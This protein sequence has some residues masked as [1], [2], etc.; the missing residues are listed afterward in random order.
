[1]TEWVPEGQT[2]NQTS[3]WKVLVTLQKRVHKKQPELWKNK[4]WILHQNNTPAYNMLSV[5]CYLVARG[6]QV[7]EHTSHLILQLFPFS[8]D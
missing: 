6:T 5:K 7:L 1:M 3:Y 2:A 4:L 8:K